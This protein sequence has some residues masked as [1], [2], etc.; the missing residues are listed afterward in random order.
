MVEFESA[1]ECSLLVLHVQ[2]A[3][4][5]VSRVF[6]EPAVILSI[7]H[8]RHQRDIIS[9][10]DDFS[11]D[12]AIRPLSQDHPPAAMLDPPADAIGLLLLELALIVAVD[13]DPEFVLVLPADRLVLLLEFC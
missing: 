13:H 2:W 3:Q 5:P 4:S 6:D 12:L 8:L 9:F 10:F 11:V 1:M 7:L